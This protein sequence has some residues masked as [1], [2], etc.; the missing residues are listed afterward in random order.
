MQRDAQAGRVLRPLDQRRLHLVRRRVAI[1]EHR[2]PAA[3]GH[4]L[5]GGI[6]RGR[7]PLERGV[8]DRRVRGEHE[9]THRDRLRQTFVVERA[10][11]V[12]LAA[13]GRRV[14]RRQVQRKDVARRV[15]D[16]HA[17]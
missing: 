15:G 17:A 14:D 5:A 10:E 11:G 9:R 7:Q 8:E 4:D 6:G 16:G 3:Q 2:G 12:G 13:G 1:D